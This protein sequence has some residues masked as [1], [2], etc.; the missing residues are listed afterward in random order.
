MGKRKSRKDRK[1]KNHHLSTE[2]ITP[3]EWE[4]EYNLLTKQI[5][6]DLGIN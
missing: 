1:K 4:R 6:I 5:K 2:D 3:E